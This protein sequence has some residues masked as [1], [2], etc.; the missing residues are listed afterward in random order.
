VT[1]VN[2]FTI[3]AIHVYKYIIATQTIV[4]TFVE[5]SIINECKYFI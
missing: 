5:G 2:S 1:F 3:Y 4:L